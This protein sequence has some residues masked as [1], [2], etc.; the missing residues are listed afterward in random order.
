MPLW[1]EDLLEEPS[2]GLRLIAGSRGLRLRGPITWVHASEIPD[3]SPWMEGGEVLLTTG[4]GVLGSAELQRKLMADLDGRGIAAVG[5]GVG[6]CVDE[7]P[8]ALREEA[9]ARDLPL[10]TVPY[11]VP[12][13]AV[14]KQIAREIFNEQY[15]M[16]RGAVD[17]HRR[18]L[19]T[20]L[21]GT[22]LGGVLATAGRA[23]PDYT[24][25]LFDYYGAPLAT[26]AA[27]G[28]TAPDPEELWRTVGPLLR[29]SERI[30]AHIG[31]AVAIGAAVRLGEQVEAYVVMLGERSPLEHELL[32]LEQ[33]LA[34]VSL[35]LAR[36]QSARDARRLLVDELL[37]EAATGRIGGQALSE[38]LAHVGIDAARGYAVL[39]IRDRSDGAG[40]G[41]RERTLSTVVEDALAP[42][43]TPVLGRRD[44]D[45]YAIVPAG[46]PV[47]DEAGAAEAVAAAVQERGWPQIVIG[48]SNVRRDAARLRAAMREAHAA[49]GVDA[50][51]AGGIRDIGSLGLQA[52]MAGIDDDDAGAAAFV[53]HVLGP[54]IRHDRLQGTNLEATLRA[55][56][57]HGCRPG[58][59]ADELCIHRHTLSYR[60]TRIR[61][62]TAL[63]PRAGEHL[64]S[65]GLALELRA[66]AAGSQVADPT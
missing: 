50:Q 35:E 51:G 52:L 59:A 15:A 18:L 58:P 10:F 45:L 28:R 16:L 48:R 8:Q 56:L 1:L 66:R 64:L 7:V 22:G 39:C 53:N 57:R 60:L 55:Y 20:V 31:N 61:N 49:A 37:D 26:C 63:D 13:I 62:L 24:C 44:C 27:D 65:F 41:V 32:L 36:G 40:G 54:V 34:G 17:L 29:D 9:D 2:L 23:L 47:P 12:F 6:V 25:V 43:G 33:A 5:F 38:R 14:T 46:S 30:E 4:L 21:G 19:A 3:P 42:L 11:D